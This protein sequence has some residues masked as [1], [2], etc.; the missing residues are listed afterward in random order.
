MLYDV[1]TFIINSQ[2]KFPKYNKEHRNILKFNSKNSTF[3]F[4]FY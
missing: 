1:H 2:L 4:S 3:M